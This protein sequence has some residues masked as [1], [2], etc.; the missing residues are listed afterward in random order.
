MPHLGTQDQIDR[1]ARQLGDSRRRTDELAGELA[2]AKRDTANVFAATKEDLKRNIDSVREKIESRAAAAAAEPWDRIGVKND[3]NYIKANFEELRE[4][5]Q[6]TFIHNPTGRRAL[7]F[8]SMM[9]HRMD[10]E[11]Y[12]ERE[13]HLSNFIAKIY[14]IC[15]IHDTED[16]VETWL[17]MLAPALLSEQKARRNH[18]QEGD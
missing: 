16:S 9:G 6:Q 4:V 7:A 13:K 10:G 12:T 2:T 3:W 1:L 18:P 8:L 15:G 5:F 11:I 14:Y 17:E